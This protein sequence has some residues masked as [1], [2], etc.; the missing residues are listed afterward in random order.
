LD[1]TKLVGVKIKVKEAFDG[2]RHVVYQE[3]T[4]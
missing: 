4:W 2:R 1:I 3:L